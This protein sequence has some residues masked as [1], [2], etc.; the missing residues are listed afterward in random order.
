LPLTEADAAAGVDR[1]MAAV[2][3]MVPTM[4]FKGDSL[5]NHSE[6]RE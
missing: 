5:S 3:S 1:A 6:F 4:Y 2:A